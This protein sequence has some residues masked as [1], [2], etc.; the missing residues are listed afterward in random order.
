MGYAQQF[1]FELNSP[2]EG[3]KTAKDRA[4]Q[5]GLRVDISFKHR[6]FQLGPCCSHRNS[7]PCGEFFEGRAFS[8]SGGQSGLGRRKAESAL[9][10]YG[11]EI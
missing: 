3:S 6:G 10:F 5:L 8:Q 9:E 7:P 1:L 4:D 11:I 2:H